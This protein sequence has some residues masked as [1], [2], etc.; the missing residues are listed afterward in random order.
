MEKSFGSDNHSGVHPN[1]LKAIIEANKGH[2]HSYGDDKLTVSAIQKIKSL[3]NDKTEVA[4]VFNGTG[5]NVI[6]LSTMLKPFESIICSSLAHIN[7]DEC[8][9]PERFTGCKLITISTPNGKLTPNLIRPHLTGFGVEHHSQPKV[10]SISQSTELGTVYTPGEIIALAKLAHDNNMYLHMDGSRIAN[11]TASLNIPVADFTLN[12]GV[13]VLSFG[14]TKNGL[15]FGEAIVVLNPLLN[16]NLKFIRKQGMQLYSKM[17]FIAAQFIA[18]LENDLWLRNALHANRMAKILCNEL[19]KIKGINLTQKVDANG[20]FLLLPEHIIEPLREQSF[21]YTWD[22]STSEIR[23]MC[24]FDT[25][26]EDIFDFIQKIKTL[27]A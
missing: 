18:Y 3:F 25:T 21:F 16:D 20:I 1:V 23:L 26:E 22:E 2:V 13:D 12:A 9:A 19:A 14:G 4:F 27:L 24:S 6:G 11:A 15:M 10:I 7:V 5:A 8:G 17:R